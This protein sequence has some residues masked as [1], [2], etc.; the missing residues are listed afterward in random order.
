MSTPTNWTFL[1]NSDIK[2]ASVIEKVNNTKGEYTNEMST[3]TLSNITKDRYD[4]AEFTGGT[5]GSYGITIHIQF[6]SAKKHPYLILEN[7]TFDTSTINWRL[8]GYTSNSQSNGVLLNAYDSMPSSKANKNNCYC[9]YNATAPGTYSHFWLVLYQID[10]SSL[11][12]GQLWLQQESYKFSRPPTN[13]KILN[14]EKTILN[15]TSGGIS[16][17]QNLY[18]KQ[19][20]NFSTPLLS[21]TDLTNFR[22]AYKTLIAAP[23]WLIYPDSLGTDGYKFLKLN[24]IASI[25]EENKVSD[26]FSMKW[27]TMESYI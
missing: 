27:A 6:A 3:S 7:M 5:G 13:F 25:N 24:L 1:Y 20:L 15:T 4:L 9:F 8:Y 2:H 16:S 14:V 12:I 23:F 17:K 11:K 10:L 26:K 18:T 22:L 21:G 19:G